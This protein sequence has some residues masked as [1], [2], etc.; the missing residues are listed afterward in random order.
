MIDYYESHFLCDLDED[1]VLL[2]GPQVLHDGS[3]FLELLG[4]EGKDT[5]AAASV[6]WRYIAGV[7]LDIDRSIGCVPR[8]LD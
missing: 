6:W 3:G 8:L 1:G 5:L 2:G 4:D 7:S